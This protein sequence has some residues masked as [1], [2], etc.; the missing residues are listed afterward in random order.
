MH[1]TWTMCRHCRRRSLDPTVKFC[2]QQTHM[3]VVSRCVPTN[4]MAWMPVRSSGRDG[5]E[6][7]GTGVAS[8]TGPST[9]VGLT[10]PTAMDTLRTPASDGI[11]ARPLLSTSPECFSSCMHDMYEASTGKAGVREE[12]RMIGARAALYRCQLERGRQSSQSIRFGSD[13]PEDGVQLPKAGTNRQ[14]Q[15]IESVCPQQFAT[16]LVRAAKG[17]TKGAAKTLQKVQ[18]RGDT[19]SELRG[20]QRQ[21]REARLQAA[22]RAA[23]YDRIAL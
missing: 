23:T 13:G 11:R 9:R 4:A 22:G 3:C 10:E 15:H 7:V 8:G 16:L 12:E 20:G 2:R 17:E 1:A 21:V 18:Q 5:D 6:S 14:A 19:S